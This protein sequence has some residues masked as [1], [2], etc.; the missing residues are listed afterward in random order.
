MANQ[1]R[2]VPSYR[3]KKSNG[4]KYGCV[5]LPDGRGGRHDILLGKFGTKESR[6]EYARVIAEWEAADRVVPKAETALDLTINE[7]IHDYWNHAKQHYRHADG[8]PTNELNDLRLS[9]RPLKTTYGHTAARSFGPLALK[10][11]RQQL[12]TKPITTR[13]RVADPETGQRVWRKKV[14][15]IGLARG[16][17]N[18]RINRIRRLFRWA[19][20]NELVPS[21]VLEGLRAVEGLKLG[22]SAARETARVRPVSTALVEDTLPHLAPTIADIVRLLM[23]TGMRCG[24]AVIMRG[25]DIDM[26]GAVWLFRPAHHKL[27]H[28]GRDRIVALGPRAQAIIRR[29]LGTDMQRFL[30]S[31]RDSVRSF[32]QC[33]REARKSPVQPSQ[34]NRAKRNPRR[35]PRECYDVRAIA[36]SVRRACIKHELECWHPHQLRHT[37]ASEIRKQFGLDAAR[38]ALGHHG[39]AITSHYAELDAGKVVQVAA[40]LG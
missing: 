26:A 5:S 31:P 20:E 21:S 25:C 15:R 27:S 29:Y 22:R 2:H 32:R 18:Q 35:K 12:I 38:A 36:H 7:L 37:V 6:A 39:A 11:I 33:Q 16:V 10:A 4:R 19:V 8:T 9:F 14:L 30:F 40:K 13:I 3:C 24:E 28:A 1:S 17:I 23:L 34:R